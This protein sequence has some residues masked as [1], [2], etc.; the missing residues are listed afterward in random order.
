MTTQDISASALQEALQESVNAV[1]SAAV[2]TDLRTIAFGLVLLARLFP[3]FPAAFTPGA[4]QDPGQ[5][6][7]NPP[8]MPHANG[9][10]DSG[11]GNIIGLI[12]EKLERSR[13]AIEMVY[14]DRDGQLSLGISPRRLSSDK[15][16]ATR[17]IAFLYASG[18]QAAGM[19]EWTPASA[20]RA[21]VSDFGKL[22]SK[23]FA[24]TIAKMSGEDGVMV[25]GKGPSRDLKV[26][27]I[28][29]HTAAE[30]VDRLVRESPSGATR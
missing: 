12:A 24:S 26:N 8:P 6:D 28:G 14:T 23:N 13:E 7:F 19:E 18:R 25:H 20:I 5:K 4:S 15:A 9:G 11:S 3:G 22:D 30:L 27:R 1:E 2:P 10:G 29:Y 16:T 21:V 17:E